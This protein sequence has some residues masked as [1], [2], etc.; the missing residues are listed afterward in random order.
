MSLLVADTLTKS[1]GGAPAVGGGCRALAGG[2]FVGVLG[3]RGLGK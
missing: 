3:P 1:W 2:G